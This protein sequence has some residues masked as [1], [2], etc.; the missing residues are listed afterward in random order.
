MENGRTIH[1]EEINNQSNKVNRVKLK[2]PVKPK[3]PTPGRRPLVFS[4]LGDV[5]F[6][7][8]HPM[9]LDEHEN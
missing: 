5:K 4:Q 9:T 2:T 7:K 3:P 1:V 8:M 6:S